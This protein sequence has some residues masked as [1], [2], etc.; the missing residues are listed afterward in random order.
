VRALTDDRLRRR[1]AEAAAR[2]VATV[3]DWDG[4]ARRTLGVYRIAAAQTQTAICT[5]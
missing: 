5:S 2:D 3:Y 4:I 1:I